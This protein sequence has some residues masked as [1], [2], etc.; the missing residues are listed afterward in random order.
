MKEIGVVATLTLKKAEDQ[1]VIE[2]IKALGGKANVAQLM[3]FDIFYPKKKIKGNLQKLVTYWEEGFLLNHLL[4][5]EE[6]GLA[7]KQEDNFIL[8]F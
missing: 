4:E 3:P 5:L 6:Q 8:K 1:G 2:A 7:Q